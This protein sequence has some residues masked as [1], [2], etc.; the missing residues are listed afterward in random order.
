MLETVQDVRI[1][2]DDVREVIDTVDNVNEAANAVFIASLV[3]LSFTVVVVALA[4]YFRKKFMSIMTGVL[5]FVVVIGSLVLMIVTLLYGLAVGDSCDEVKKYQSNLAVERSPWN[6]QAIIDN[7]LTTT[8]SSLEELL[9]PA[10]FPP[11]IIDEY[12]QCPKLVTAVQLYAVSVFADF[13]VSAR[14]KPNSCFILIV[15][16]SR[17]QNQVF[18]LILMRRLSA[19]SSITKFWTLCNTRQS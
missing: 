5:A 7:G 16:S 12:F 18:A 3:V 14:S 4:V 19:A 9:C 8:N 6:F 10:P 1:I 11:T 2:E 17:S 13:L 15:L